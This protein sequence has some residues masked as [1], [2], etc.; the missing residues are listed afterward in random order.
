MSSEYSERYT[1]HLRAHSRILNGERTETPFESKYVKLIKK[2]PEKKKPSSWSKKS[3][4]PRRANSKVSA[5]KP[6]YNFKPKVKKKTKSKNKL[7]NLQTNIQKKENECMNKEEENINGNYCTIKN[8]DD[9][10]NNLMTKSTYFFKNDLKSNYFKKNNESNGFFNN[11]FQ[12]DNF[13]K[14]VKINKVFNGKDSLENY[15]DI[16]KLR[17]QASSVRDKIRNNYF[18]CKSN[19]ISNLNTQNASTYFK[20]M[21]L[22]QEIQNSF[23]NINKP[24]SSNSNYNMLNNEKNFLS[25]MINKSNNNINKSKGNIKNKSHDKNIYNNTSNNH[26]KENISY[27]FFDK[28]I[29]MPKKMKKYVNN[30][31]SNI[32]YKEKAINNN[33]LIKQQFKKQN[34]KNN[35]RKKA[36]NSTDK[37]NKILNNNIKDFINSA[38]YIKSKKNEILNYK[39]NIDYMNLI[40]PEN[41][42][43]NVLLKKMPSSRFKEKSFDLMNYIFNLQN[44]NAKNDA[45]NNI[46]DYN[47]SFHTIYPVNEYNPLINSKINIK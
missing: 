7:E 46:I 18:N 16:F 30:S 28:S 20:A 3:F 25:E 9:N 12:D 4:K 37:N 26:A 6:N 13:N 31:K 11:T 34:N 40:N 17:K 41:L 35:F 45:I 29:K 43:L 1:T 15:F 47:N 19:S 14:S 21:K 36:K 23:K 39:N 24:Y 27:Y 33:N 5:S 2:F 44:H 42:K 38:I 10:N 8:N 22:K 32:N